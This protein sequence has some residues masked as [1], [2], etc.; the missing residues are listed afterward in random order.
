MN[1]RSAIPSTRVSIIA[2]ILLLAA[3]SLGV[4]VTR[5]L[6]VD[7]GTSSGNQFA[8]DF[9]TAYDDFESGG[10]TGGF[11]WLDNWTTT[12]TVT[13]T[14]ANA[15]YQ[16]TYHMEV[17][18]GA[19]AKRSTNLYG[20]TNMRL[21]VRAKVT[22]LT[23]GTQGYAE[24]SSDGT[25]W[26]VVRNWTKN[27]AQGVYQFEDIDL[28]PYTMS[29]Q[30]WVRF[31]LDAGGGNHLLHVDNVTF[32]SRQAPPPTPTP[33]PTP[34]PP[35]TVTDNF[36]SG[37]LTGGT[38]WLDNWTTAG[39]VTVTSANAPYA[40][41]YHVQVDK[42]AEAKRS[43]DLTGQSSMRLKFQAKVTGLSGQRKAYAEVSSDGTNWSIVRTWTTSDPDGVYQF[44]D[45]DLSPYTM[46]SQFWVRFRIDGAG[47]GSRS[48]YVDDIVISQ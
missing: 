37:N 7:Q 45:I 1:F 34:A 47:G 9:I 5:A 13:V 41:T 42:G 2:V 36:E 43:V 32:A 4:G 24:V 10:L 12:G 18:K 3:A 44:D 15:P 25:N 16:G 40:G 29:T 21:Q 11:G 14:S 8:S 6:F 39:T 23:G 33:T 35:I 31:R 30:F 48:L 19:D 17:D 28:S 38:G 20:K 27:D 46:S 26:T 22:S